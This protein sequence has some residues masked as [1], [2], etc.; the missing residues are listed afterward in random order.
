MELRRHVQLN[1][2]SKS[3]S[4]HVVFV[5]YFSVPFWNLTEAIENINFVR[6]P[7]PHM[8]HILIMSCHKRNSS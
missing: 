7:A 8:T 4:R 2:I 6:Q 5:V 1:A 3:H